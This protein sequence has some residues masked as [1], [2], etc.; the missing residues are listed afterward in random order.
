[1]TGRNVQKIAKTINKTTNRQS[2]NVRLFILP[3]SV[4]AEMSPVS[5]EFWEYYHSDPSPDRCPERG[6]N[7]PSACG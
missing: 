5:F 4:D 7:R 3:S 2:R 1:M 6:T